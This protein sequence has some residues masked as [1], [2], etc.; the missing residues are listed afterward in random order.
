[1]QLN[2][3]NTFLILGGER[4]LSEGHFS[5][6]ILK[7]TVPLNRINCVSTYMFPFRYNPADESWTELEV[8]LPKAKVNLAAIMA[9][10]DWIYE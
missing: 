1:M 7:Y 4:R 10:K 3:N 8:R 9:K 5:D 6:A 2:S